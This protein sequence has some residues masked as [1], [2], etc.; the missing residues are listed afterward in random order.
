[1]NRVG[2]GDAELDVDGVRLFPVTAGLA[3]FTGGVTGVAKTVMGTGLQV[4]VAYLR[5]QAERDVVMGAGVAGTAGGEED[6][7]EAVRRPCTKPGCPAC[8]K[9]RTTPILTPAVRASCRW[10]SPAAIRYAR[11]RL[12]ADP[13]HERF[14]V[15]W[16]E[17]GQPHR[18]GG[19]VGHRKRPPGD[20]ATDSIPSVFRHRRWLY[21]PALARYAPAVREEAVPDRHP[22]ARR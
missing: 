10:V 15:G 13:D 14:T 11:I 9:S 16:S 19:D 17:D 21:H 5:G 1:M 22:A 20:M 8:S 2:L 18:Q 12:R 4:A 6:G 3:G 7:A